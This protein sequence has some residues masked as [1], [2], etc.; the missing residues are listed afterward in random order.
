MWKYQYNILWFSHCYMLNNNLG[1]CS[2]LNLD[3]KCEIS[4]IPECLKMTFGFPPSYWDEY[5]K[6]FGCKVPILTSPTLCCIAVFLHPCDPCLISTS[7]KVLQYPARAG[8]WGLWEFKALGTDVCMGA[9]LLMVGGMK[10]S[11]PVQPQAAALSQQVLG[12]CCSHWDKVVR[13]HT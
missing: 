2:L 7:R 3:Q 5:I 13:P 4:V 10:P 12:W 11:C 6:F 1:L 8:Y 9:V